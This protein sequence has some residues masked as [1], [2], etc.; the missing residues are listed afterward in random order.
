MAITTVDS[1]NGRLKTTSL[2]CDSCGVVTG[3]LQGNPGRMECDE[4][5]AETGTAVGAAAA[6]ADKVKAAQAESRA[7][8][9]AAA[10]RRRWPAGYSSDVKK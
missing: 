10:A 2:S 3:M 7:A 1:L 4:C 6:R 8:A 9:R 5:A